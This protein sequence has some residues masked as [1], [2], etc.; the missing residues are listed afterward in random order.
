GINGNPALWIDFTRALENV[1]ARKSWPSVHLHAAIAAL[2]DWRARSQSTE[3]CESPTS[4]NGSVMKRP[5]AG[6]V[7]TGRSVSLPHHEA[8]EL[9][10][11]PCES[12]TAATLGSSVA[13]ST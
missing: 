1:V 11:S 5:Y 3:P 12:R 13:L 2:P 9:V 10:Q 8:F 6:A 7:C 4:M